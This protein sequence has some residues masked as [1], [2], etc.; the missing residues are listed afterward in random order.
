MMVISVEEMQ[1]TLG[2]GKTRERDYV[3]IAVYGLRV[4]ILMRHQFPDCHPRLTNHMPIL[5]RKIL[6]REAVILSYCK[7]KL[8]NVISHTKI[9]KI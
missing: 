2:F 5:I 3:V 4:L 6:K 1:R 9:R 7:L 8:A